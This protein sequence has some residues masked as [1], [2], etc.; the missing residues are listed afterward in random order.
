MSM[1]NEFYEELQNS[2]NGY[3]IDY[4]IDEDDKDV[5]VLSFKIDCDAVIAINKNTDEIVL[6]FED[7]NMMY[8]SFSTKNEF[9]K[10]L[11]FISDIFK[12]KIKACN[13]KGM[14]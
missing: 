7:G 14:H 4:K 3:F 8:T 5:L 13:Y 12:K 6:S 11:F 1:F 10:T 9:D 2:L